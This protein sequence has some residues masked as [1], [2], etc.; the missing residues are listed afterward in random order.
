MKEYTYDTLKA[1]LEEYKGGTVAKMLP[2]FTVY[3]AGDITGVT[4]TPFKLGAIAI[5]FEEVVG[6]DINDYLPD[7]VVSILDDLEVTSE[8]AITGDDETKGLTLL[9]LTEGYQLDFALKYADTVAFNDAITISDFYIAFTITSSDVSATISSGNIHFKVGE[10]AKPLNLRLTA[11]VP[12][13]IFEA[14]M[15]FDSEGNQPEH[16]AQAQQYLGDLKKEGTSIEVE[17]IRFLAALR[18]KNYALHLSVNNML[19]VHDKFTVRRFQADVNYVGGTA[20]G[21]SVLAYT[22]IEI[23]FENDPLEI[24]LVARYESMAGE[25]KW[26]FAGSIARPISFG[27]MIDDL[28]QLFGSDNPFHLPDVINDT[29][30]DKLEL[31]FEGSSG[32][33]NSRDYH[34]AVG[35]SV[36]V[37]GKHLQLE[38]DADYKKTG[39]QY[40]LDLKGSALYADRQFTI[41]FKKK[42]SGTTVGAGSQAPL[43]NASLLVLKY[44]SN[45]DKISLTELLGEITDEP[46]IVESFPDVS[47]KLDEVMFAVLKEETGNKFLFGLELELPIDLD[48][49]KLPVVGNILNSHGKYGIGSFKFFLSSQHLYEHEVMFFPD[50][51]RS[52]IMGNLPTHPTPPIPQQSVPQQVTVLKRGANFRAILDLGTMQKTLPPPPSNELPTSSIDP[53]STEGSSIGN[54][55]AEGTGTPPTA[56]PARVSDGQASWMTIEKSIGPVTIAR[57]GASYKKGNLWFFLSGSFGIGGF[58]VSLDGLGIG[59]P[60]KDFSLDKIDVTL[61]GLGV[62]IQKGNLSIAGGFLHMHHEADEVNNK[63]AYDEYSG[64][65][66]VVFTPF[67]LVGMG[68]YAKYEGHPSLFLFVALGFPIA[69]DPSLIIE[70]MSLGFGIHRDF[71]APRLGHVLEFP[72]IQ[73]SVTPPPPID[74]DVMVASLNQYFPPTTDQFFVVAGIKFKAL[75]VVDTLA[76]FAVKFGRELE[77]DMMGVSSIGYPA[78]MIEMEWLA[79]IKP[80]EGYFFMGGQLTSRSYVLVP[81]ARMTGGFAVAFWTNG[82]H[83]GDFAVS[84]GGY[85]PRYNRPLHYPDQIPRLGISFQMNGILDIKGGVYFAVTPQC[86]MLGASM[87]ASLH[88]GRVSGYIRMSLDALIWFQPFHYDALISADVGVKVTIPAVFFDIHIDIHLHA[89][90]HVWGPDFAGKAYLDVGP[91]TFTV[92]F[93]GASST[94]P[95]PVGWDDFSKKFLSAGQ[96]C[97]VTVAKGLIRK[98]KNA[99]G[100]EVYVVNPKEMEIEVKSIIPISETGYYS[101]G[102]T[103]MGIKGGGYSAVLT[104]EIK[105]FETSGFRAEALPGSVPAAIWGDQGLVT[106]KEPSSEGSLKTNVLTGYSIRPT[107]TPL[108]DETHE[109]DKEKLAYNVDLAK[110]KDLA[111]ARS[112][113]RKDVKFDRLTPLNTYADFTGLTSAVNPTDLLHEPVLIDFN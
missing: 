33:G 75:G 98:A 97:G 78:C 100:E 105:G 108:P 1:A 82:E 110:P 34:F 77:I 47:V 22:D 83:S 21:Y 46:D 4:V 109:I 88:M 113:A 85:H 38:I 13:L 104:K 58:A 94:K 95:L 41:E 57:I 8:D 36:P 44:I 72:L 43:A 7:K 65:V 76:M 92:E 106:M 40:E 9:K 66:Q 24:G 79:K 6:V 32:G 30:I 84:V 87:E 25:K 20:G 90:V 68:S 48:F 103:P 51:D 99:N 29:I 49:G 93:G 54:A 27:S 67:S 3:A 86:I 28:C 12:S 10:E 61:M 81:E 69:V 17:E 71:I 42:S 60:V 112:F 45:G 14:E 111:S 53:S 39:Q 73:A 64:L 18:M 101:P 50:E 2:A 16:Q 15:D 26:L 35:L 5:F 96:V 52:F 55:G 63:P 11:K 74:I 23:G 107:D 62:V 91:K 19:D 59:A 80:N 89:D 31:S 102:I 56:T 70:G 37:Q